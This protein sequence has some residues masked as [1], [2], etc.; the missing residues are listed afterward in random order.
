VG[1]IPPSPPNY[2]YDILYT[3]KWRTQRKRSR[4]LPPPLPPPQKHPQKKNIK[5]KI[6]QKKIKKKK[7]KKMFL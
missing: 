4:V 3:H 7:R 2:T 5:I 1:I 6:K